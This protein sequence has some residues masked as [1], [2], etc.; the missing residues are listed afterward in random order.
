MLLFIG[1]EDLAGR[2][3]SMLIVNK[4]IDFTFNKSREDVFVPIAVINFPVYKKS[5][6]TIHTTSQTAFKISFDFHGEEFIFEI[7]FKLFNIQP[8]ELCILC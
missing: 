6:C 7:R 5:R 2:A 1:D 4:H 8:N 3:I